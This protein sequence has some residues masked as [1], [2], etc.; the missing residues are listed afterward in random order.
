MVR[1]AGDKATAAGSNVGLHGIMYSR[2]QENA[3]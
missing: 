3:E 2:P 1:F